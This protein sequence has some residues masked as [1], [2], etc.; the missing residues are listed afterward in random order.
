MND[1]YLDRCPDK[2][3]VLLRKKTVD[4]LREKK[5]MNDWEKRIR[6]E[7]CGCITCEYCNQCGERTQVSDYCCETNDTF[8]LL[9]REIKEAVEET[10]ELCE[11]GTHDGDI[12][13]KPLSFKGELNEV[14]NKRGIE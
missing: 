6:E 13:C 4:M 7:I 3:F 14:L 10:A 1:F 2:S 9:K 12:Y 5:R 11:E 8:N